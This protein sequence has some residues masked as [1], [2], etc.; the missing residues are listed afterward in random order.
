MVV[1]LINGKPLSIPWVK[2]YAQAIVEAWNP[3]VEGGTAVAGILFG[4]RNPVGKLTISFPYHVGQQPVYYNQIPGWHAERYVD[5]PKEPLFVFGY[6]LSYTTFEY[7]N[8]QLS[9]TTL[10]AGET[11]KVSVD[12]RNTGQRA[13]TEIVQLY[14]NDVYSSVTTP[15]KELKAFQRVELQAGEDQTVQ[16]EVPYQ[17]TRACQ[18]IP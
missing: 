18:S 13:G 1:L 2:E 12:V 15:I 10:Q 5:M 14:I 9:T 6:G 4:D 16:L 17:A 3:G 8:L 7:A 11:L